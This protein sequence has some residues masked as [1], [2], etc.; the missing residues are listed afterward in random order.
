MNLPSD[1]NPMEKPSGRMLRRLREPKWRV[2]RIP[3]GG[4]FVLLGLVGFLPIVGFWMVPVGLAI[5]AVD[6]PLAGRLLR[7]L[8][9][10]FRWLRRSFHRWKGATN[11][12]K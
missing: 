11:S 12:P 3:A 6:F 1:P 8:R 4:V 5:L 10:I 9:I 2:V 7:K